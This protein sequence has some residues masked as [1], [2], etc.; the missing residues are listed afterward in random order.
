MLFIK[1]NHFDIVY[2]LIVLG[3]PIWER[4]LEC[5]DLL[6]KTMRQILLQNAEILNL[7]AKVKE[8]GDSKPS[9]SENQ[10]EAF[11]E[12]KKLLQAS[13]RQ[14]LMKDI[15]IGK[16]TKQVQEADDVQRTKEQEDDLLKKDQEIEQLKRNLQDAEY[17]LRKKE[18]EQKL[19]EARSELE[20]LE[21]IR[22]DIEKLLRVKDAEIKELQRKNDSKENCATAQ[23]TLEVIQ[24]NIIQLLHLKDKELEELR[25]QNNTSMQDCEKDLRASKSEVENLKGALMTAKNSLQLK[26][27]ELQKHVKNDEER[28]RE[29]EEERKKIDAIRLN[30]EELIHRQVAELKKLQ[31]RLNDAVEEL[32][33]KDEAKKL[34]KALQDLED[35]LRERWS[36][37]S[38]GES[39]RKRLELSGIFVYLI[40]T[41][42]K[43]QKLKAKIKEVESLNHQ[44][45]QCEQKLKQKERELEVHSKNDEAKI[46]DAK[47]ELE[48]LTIIQKDVAEL[49]RLKN[50]EIKRLRDKCEV[51]RRT[52]EDV[53]VT[54][55]EFELRRLHDQHKESDMTGEE[56][57]ISREQYEE[58]LKEKEAEIDEY[59]ELCKKQAR[60]KEEEIMELKA[61]L[62]DNGGFKSAVVCSPW[63][64]TH[65]H[66]SRR[67][68]RTDKHMQDKYTNIER[69]KYCSINS[70]ISCGQS[71]CGKADPHGGR[72]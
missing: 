38:C 11:N 44:L 37:T 8:A 62:E 39:C 3:A 5:K 30:V 33:R 19:R 65:R 23:D 46:L 51:T 47:T 35:E 32:I 63:C 58:E 42:T 4:Y 48:K 54:G 6:Q 53:R 56:A 43:I 41:W 20:Q 66:I 70:S 45:Q 71:R 31:K 28:I 14:L 52:E 25:R 1:Q 57:R 17:S 13:M 22:N 21:R 27:E 68:A 29:T 69:K 72:V 24:R 9:M 40:C 16:L 36:D 7:Q 49:L 61:T 10:E 50:E 18:S 12:C 59:R 2:F 26:D 64:N 15:E 55:E 34:K 67:N 60:A